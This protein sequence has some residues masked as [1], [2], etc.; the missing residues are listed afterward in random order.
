MDSPNRSIPDLHER[1]KR[2]APAE[3]F[4]IP[5]GIADSATA[6][7]EPRGPG[8]QR[9]DT[10][11]RDQAHNE[12]F[13]ERSRN[14]PRVDF[15]LAE[16][17]A[18]PVVGQREAIAEAIRSHQVVVVCG[19]T[20][21]GKT[22]QLPKICLE[23]GRGV[24]GLI[25]HTQPRRIA[26]R[27]V[28][29]RIADEL[30]SPL[31]VQV[32]FKIRF[33]DRSG[34]R[35]G[36]AGGRSRGMGPDGPYV[37]L[38][39]DGILLAETRSDRLLQAYDTI[40][41]DEAHERSLNIDF[42]L[43]YL[44]NIQPRRP[45]LKIIITSATIDPQRFSEHFGGAPI[46]EVSGRTY[47]VETV[48]RAPEE[49]DDEG[50][51]LSLSIV[52]A[53]DEA[54]R[55]HPRGDVLIF[56]PGER[57]IR[58]TAEALR[59]H[60]P[61]G[62]TEILPLFSRLSTDEQNRVFKPKPGGVSRRV[63][64]ATNVAETS[65]TV[66]GIRVV[67]DPGLARMSRYSPRSRVQR[68]PIEMISRA[69][70][71]Q[72]RGRA[73]RTAPGT[74]IRLY[75]EDEYETRAR[76]TDP[77]I[78]RTN[79]AAVI[80]QMESLGIGEVE[81]FPFI[82][83]PEARQIR[84]GYE[85]LHELGAVDEKHALTALGRELARLPIDP[86]L[87]RMVL[88]ARREA[89]L[90]EVL[91]IAAALSVQ[92]PRERPM[93]PANLAEKADAAHEQFRHPASDFLAYLNLWTWY[94]EQAKHLSQNKLR[95]L[96]KEMFLN[97][98]RLREWH[99]I[100]SQLHAVVSEWGGESFR[101]NTDA[102][103]YDSIHKSLLAGLVTSVGVL[104][105]NVEYAGPNQLKFHIFPGSALF[106]SKPK[107]IMAAELV[108]T[109][110][111]YARTCAMI[112]PAWI[113][114]LG[115][116]LVKRSYSEPEWAAHSGG[117][118]VFAHET[119]TLS[120]LTLVSRR[121]V[122]LG[123]IDP[124]LS[125]QIFISRALVE[126]DFESRAPFLSHNKRMLDDG[127]KL[128][129]KARKRDLVV[130][131]DLI[132]AFYDRVVPPDVFNGPGFEKWRR[133]AERNNPEL[134]RMSMNDVLVPG[135]L[136][137]S[138]ADAA[139][140]PDQFHLPGVSLALS[141]AL[142]PGEA[143]DGVTVT[144]PAHALQHLK[145][146]P[147]EWVV[148]GLLKEK[149]VALLR[150][151]P[152]D[153]RR[154]LG[155]APEAAGEILA[156]TQAK[157][158]GQS[159]A[160]AVSLLDA[161]A[162]EAGNLVGVRV[163]RGDF[164]LETL[165]DYLKM[166]FRVVDSRGGEL[167]VGRDLD[168]LRARLADVLPREEFIGS[169]DAPSPFPDRDGL[170]D[171]VFED[172]PDRV[173]VMRAGFPIAAYPAVIDRGSSVS[174]RLLP[175]AE[176]AREATRAG[177]RRL[178]FL[179]LR[180]EILSLVDTLPEIEKARAQF[181]AMAVSIDG[182]KSVRTLDD[183]LAM[184]IAD[185]AFLAS[186]PFSGDVRTRAEFRSR[187]DSGWNRLGEAASQAGAVMT[188]LLAADHAA[189]LRLESLPRGESAY[190]AAI[191]DVRAQRAR[192][193]APGFAV[194]CEFHWLQ[195]YPRFLRA[196]ELRLEKLTMRGLAGIE[197]DA[198][199]MRQVSAYW[200]EYEVRR[201]RAG[202]DAGVIRLPDPPALGDLRWAI[203]EYRVSLFAQQLRTSVPISDKRLHEAIAAMGAPMR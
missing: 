70:A 81:R 78:Q 2:R 79:L 82:D 191:A 27:T 9:R 150:S 11:P 188:R 49:H 104:S 15:S 51:P 145:P 138:A 170:S 128:E 69:S 26:A 98:M 117:G 4:P 87:G 57:E 13:E 124:A 10:K 133:H 74:C 25:G 41:I 63:I 32:G 192:L 137:E 134:L 130:G 190:S 169:S 153:V 158:G 177:V 52:R 185:R 116:H 61:P 120:G 42:L 19:E 184:L 198:G 156:R 90:T 157:R 139:M 88:A 182:A 161:V 29:Q 86:R 179:Q 187:L 154:A 155:P 111:L 108:K 44:K 183:E 103:D 165:P 105:S 50:D 89:A 195:Q 163:S 189:M 168:D 14:L 1:S 94:H 118:Q 40:I 66:P 75:R 112:E 35:G 115:A 20:G 146:E 80:L 85:T 199:L 83:P 21:S 151:L 62:G 73:G 148:P 93:E 197:Q 3:K 67:I 178:F 140:F 173:T 47:P 36:G 174:L 56:L 18:L 23:I 31:G 100:H 201:P 68:L 48:Y 202:G 7:R 99:D 147:F 136:N 123:K 144:I 186:P 141:Y 6:A 37:K 131:P 129:A 30:G 34:S 119:V 149:M 125:R 107:W 110:R 109:A 121:R 162:A 159:G 53:V 176:V 72:R 24:R 160:M 167:G 127:S 84:D 59:K 194:E 39:T 164:R 43:G 96:C 91:V 71:D 143:H 55:R 22:T 97:Y 166:N 142:E 106:K 196:I 152:K 5:P 65:L 16:I 38:M 64:L 45:D 135:A 180:G 17:A 8:A 203:E 54:A 92:D 102:A 193:L 77:E 175:N 95:K 200:R 122:K 12:L 114:Q 33:S 58:E 46:I 126:G 76:F 28:A 101:F 60:H 172:L 132:H 171:W 113:E 181:A